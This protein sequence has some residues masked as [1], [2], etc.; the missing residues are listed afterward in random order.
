MKDLREETHKNKAQVAREMNMPYTTYVNYEKGTREPNSEV[1]I[2][3][4]T[5]FGVSVDYLIG[6]SESRLPENIIAKNLIPLKQIIKIPIIGRIACGKPLLAEQNYE[7]FTY[8]PDNV[9]ADF[10]LKCQ[11]DS[12]ID[13][14]IQDGDLVF[15]EESPVVENGEIAAVVIGEEAT[16]KKVY[17]QN[18]TITL[19]PANSA[20]APMVYHKEEINNIRICGKAVAVLRHI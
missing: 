8:C 15:I 20:Y 17:Y 9:K 11:G 5:Y 18:D 14:N 13:A 6:R 2:M 7:G 16:L 10:V 1:L 3:I 4:A 19:L 12:M